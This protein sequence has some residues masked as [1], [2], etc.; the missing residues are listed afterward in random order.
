[1]TDQLVC[2]LEQSHPVALIRPRGVLNAYTAAD[3][4]TALRD[5][6]VDQPVAVVVDATELVLDDDVALSV[7]A[8]AARESLRWPG[9]RFLVGG[10]GEELTAALTR[11]GITG[12]IS[13]FP[14]AAVAVALARTWPV[15]PRIRE[16][17][18]PDRFAPANARETLLRFFTECA[19]SGDPAPAELVVS[20]LVTN[21]VL[22]AGTVID[23]T[24]R[25]IAPY[26][27]IAVRDLGRGEVRLVG[28]LDDS[29]DHGRGLLLVDALAASWG[30]HV[31]QCGKVV[32]ATLRVRATSWSKDRASEQVR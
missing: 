4:R 5:A 6:V 29:A 13:L 7:I 19:I 22:H 32:W 26:L 1:M 12:Q 15:P 11:M 14:D 18:T 2:E 16:Q 21:A 20:E 27:H 3:L 17:I 8:T 25:F 28:V 24:L 23:L 9:S 30:T 31:P 10:A